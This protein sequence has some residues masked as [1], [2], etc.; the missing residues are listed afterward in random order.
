MRPGEWFGIRALLHG[1]PGVLTYRAIEPTRLVFLSGTRLV[2]LMRE[3]SDI[4]IRVEPLAQIGDRL[5]AWA[6]RDLLTPDAGRRL[7]AVLL[8]ASGM[9]EVGPDDPQVVWLTHARLAAM[10][11]RSR[12]HVGRKLALFEAEG[13][14]ARGYNRIRLL[15]AT[16][17]G[18]FAYGG[19]AA[20]PAGRGRW[21]N[22]RP[23]GARPGTGRPGCHPGRRAR[24][25]SVAGSASAGHAA[26]ARL[27][28]HPAA[29]K[30]RPCPTPPPTSAMS[31]RTCASTSA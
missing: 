11:N 9:G 7:A 18:A 15:D 12:H 14:I 17:L 27:R 13:W 5:G 3:N 31:P 6:M 20:R 10:S 4:A 28:P 1:G 24:G 22:G 21:A 30:R 26:T 25:P 8:R 2:P 29:R 19:D 23:C 16:G